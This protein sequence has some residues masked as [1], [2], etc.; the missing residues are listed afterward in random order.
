MAYR[1]LHGQC[2]LL[3]CLISTL[4]NGAPGFSV[5]QVVKSKK[6]DGISKEKDYREHWEEHKLKF[7]LEFSV[8]EEEARRQNWERNHAFI[9]E[10]NA[11]ETE[12]FE[13]EH[14]ELSH[15]SEEEI[16][17]M[18][19]GRLRPEGYPKNYP[20]DKIQP[21]MTIPK[22]LDW[23]NYDN[24]NYMAPIEDQGDCGSC[25]TFSATASLESRMAYVH[26]RPVPV[27]SKQMLVDC[28]KT[29][30]SKGCNGGYFTDA[31]DYVGRAGQE[32]KGQ[33]Y[34]HHYPYIAM[35]WNEKK[36]HQECQF[37]G[38]H[39]GGWTN[40]V[41]DSKFHYYDIK[42]NDPLAMKKA[43]LSGPVSINIKG[44]DDPRFE[45]LKAGHILPTYGCDNGK[46]DKKTGE[47]AY[48]MINVIGW[49]EDRKGN[50]YWLIRNSWGK[51]WSSGGYGKFQRTD[52]KGVVGTC[53]I[54]M[55]AGY[56][57]VVKN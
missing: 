49:G 57:N 55:Q 18:M 29:E 21:K 46:L 47:P 37:R 16:L 36:G 27:L 14:N 48:H 4:V 8:E 20:D 42:E 34:Q 15:L 44:A 53:G 13:L 35:K 33:E 26:Q 7:E 24:H 45:F 52:K 31:W 9:L 2:L 5:N 41:G 30:D 25:W 38:E 10:H 54:F 43:L 28:V 23:R 12:T 32:K 22:Q 11:N 17:G 3:I 51:S 40:R 39:I 1:H 50:K 6:S 56:P 19:G